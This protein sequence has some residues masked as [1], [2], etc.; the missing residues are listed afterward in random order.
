M[1]RKLA[2]EQGERKD[3]EPVA[4]RREIRA[5]PVQP[6]G[7]RLAGEEGLAIV[8][9]HAAAAFRLGDG[10]LDRDDL[11]G[12][13]KNRAIDDLPLDTLARRFKVIRTT[14]RP[15]IVPYL[16]G[17]HDEAPEVADALRQLEY[18]EQVGVGGIARRLQSWLVQVP[19][20]AYRAL[21]QAHAIAPVAPERY[22][23]QFVRLVNARLYDAR[24]GLHWHDN[25]QFIDAER[26][27]N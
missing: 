14:M 1:G 13:L 11:L 21:W 18:G 19:E 3:G 2:P 10:R 20:Q 6:L 23:E 4:R 15:L 25:P 7:R 16:P 17:S 22:G 27:V 12:L 9:H 8:E 26:L 24:F 5:Q